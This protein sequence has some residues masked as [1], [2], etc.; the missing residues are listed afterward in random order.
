MLRVKTVEESKHLE[1]IS[2]L[3]LLSPVSQ[4][5]AKQPG[6]KRW[7]IPTVGSKREG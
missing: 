6:S 5:S 3:H 1:I 7:E 4:L 2:E